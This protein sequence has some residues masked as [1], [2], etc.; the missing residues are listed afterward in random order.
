M[1]ARISSLLLACGI[2]LTAVQLAASSAMTNERVKDKAALSGIWVQKDGEPKI[3]FADK[4]VVKI[5][6]HGDS[7]IIAVVCKYTVDKAGLV[8]AKVTEIE[9]NDDVRQWAR[10][11]L[12]PG[13]QF[14]FKW[15]VKD[16]TARL[17]D[18]TGAQVEH[19]KSR[20]EGEYTQKK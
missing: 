14:S 8:E 5:C 3:E 10:E 19:M 18:L 15:T 4:N 1:R 17:E 16:D 7:A 9:G 12:P 6:P 20:L 13:T 11:M 2:L